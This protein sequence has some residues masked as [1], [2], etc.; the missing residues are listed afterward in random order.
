M[1]GN[2]GWK[3]E[4]VP[5][6]V[7]GRHPCKGKFGCPNTVKEEWGVCLVCKRKFKAEME[8]ERENA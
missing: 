4:R 8:Q 5:E 1:S 2:W 7:N 3:P 6:T